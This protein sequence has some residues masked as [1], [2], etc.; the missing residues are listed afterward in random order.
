MNKIILSTLCIV[1]SSVSL[2]ATNGDNLIGLGT[3]SRAMGGT[4]IAH[5]SAG[6]SATGNPALI[7]F[8]KGGEF[9]FGGTYLS[10]SVN[11][12]TTDTNGT[13][14]LSASSDAKKNTIPYAALTHN[15]DNGFSVGGSIFGAAGM[16]TDWTKGDGAIGNPSVGDFGLYSMKSN[17]TMLKISAPIAYKWKDWSFGVAPVMV[18][19]TLHM[20]FIS[21]S[22]GLVDNNSSS[23]AG[24]GLELGSVYKYS[25]LGL[26]VGV[27]YHSPVTLSYSDQISAVSKAFGYGTPVSNFETMSDVLE[28]PAE[29]GIGIDWTWDDISLTADYRNIQWGEAQGYKDFNWENQDVYSLGAEYRINELALRFGYNYGKNPIKPK[30]DSTVVSSASPATNGDVVNTFNHVMF[31]AITETHYTI[32]AGYQF[33]QAVSADLA[34]TYA[35]SPEV[36]VSAKSVGLGN[37]TVSN[38]Q[39]SASAALNVVF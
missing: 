20:S 18:F 31:P 11:V 36:T 15:L 8:S 5:F 21:P 17:L 26:S 28:Q 39:Y 34:L 13:N 1:V 7:T 22:Q 3:S 25:P 38:E 6:A 4:G 10:P 35:T 30:S 16:G 9:T 2:F 23:D 19:G 12:K 37:V 14:D 29:F 24:F 27:V 32:G 33:N